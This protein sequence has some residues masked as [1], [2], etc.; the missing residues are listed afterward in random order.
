MELYM[1]DPRF[2]I[3]FLNLLIGRKYLLFP[4]FEE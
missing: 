4:D 1:K 3:F 2:K